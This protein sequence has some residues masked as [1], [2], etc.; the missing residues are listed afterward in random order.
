MTATVPWLSCC[1]LDG[2]AY[3]VLG[4][5]HRGDQ[6][7]TEGCVA[8]EAREIIEA[9]TALERQL[10]SPAGHTRTS[11]AVRRLPWRPQADRSTDEPQATFATVSRTAAF[12]TPLHHE[13][14]RQHFAS[15]LSAAG[16]RRRCN[17]SARTQSSA[18]CP[19]AAIQP[20]TQGGHSGFESR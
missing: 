14:L 11:E 10:A 18:R 8:F 9:F 17:G 2:L 6:A 16:V 7:Q 13:P 19:L 15:R 1:L 3:G 20:L 4:H 12:E 5:H